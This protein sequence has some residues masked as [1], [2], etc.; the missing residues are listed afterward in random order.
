M[1]LHFEVVFTCF[2]R[3]DTPPQVLAALRWHLGLAEERPAGLGEHAYS[4]LAPDPHS[5]L[6]GG[7]VASLRE[8]DQGWG[9]FSRNYWLDDDLGELATVL[10][11][12][13]PHVEGPGFGGHLREEFESEPTVF[14][15]RDGGYELLRPARSGSP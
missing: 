5:R 11:L 13:A 10:E 6:P 15:F 8:Q 9:L 2:L 3:E 7:D 12:L 4:L 14:A 1:S